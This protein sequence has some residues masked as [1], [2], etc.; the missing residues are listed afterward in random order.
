V[1]KY[2]REFEKLLEDAFKYYAWINHKKENNTLLPDNIRNNIDLQNEYLADRSKIED[3]F[4]SGEIKYIRKMFRIEE[5]DLRPSIEQTPY[6][7][8]NGMLPEGTFYFKQNEVREQKPK[9]IRLPKI[10][11]V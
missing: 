10:C 1:V 4:R 11:N 6:M 3:Q 9:Q 2:A 5:T 8:R 7:Q